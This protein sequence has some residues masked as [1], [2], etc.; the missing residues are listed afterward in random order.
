MRWFVCHKE[1]LIIM[2]CFHGGYFEW[3]VREID[4]KPSCLNDIL[5]YLKNRLLKYYWMLLFHDG[6]VECD[7]IDETVPK[8]Q[9]YHLFVWYPKTCVG[10]KKKQYFS[11]LPVMQYVRRIY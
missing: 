1:Q 11:N 5:Y 2:A 6:S 8:L 4:V 9:Y 7:I 3:D 10:T